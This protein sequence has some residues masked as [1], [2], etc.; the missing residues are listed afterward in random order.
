VTID[1]MMPFYGRVDQFKEAVESVLA[2]SDPDWRLVVIDD[3]Y[4]DESAGQWLLSLNDPRVVYLRNEINL[5]INLNFQA[6]IDLAVND[7][8]TIFGCDDVMLRDYVRT[9]T[10]LVE[11]HPLA[12]FVQ[13]GV[14]VIDGDGNPTSTLV[15]WTKARYRPRI[16]GAFELTGEKLAVSI[17]RGNWMYFP[18]LC[19]RR[20]ALTKFGFRPD[21]STVQDLALAIDLVFD[22]ATLV[23]DD[24]PV[25]RYRRHAESVSSW[26]A[27]E[28]SRF[29]EEGAFFDRIA[30][31]YAQRGW[32]KAH[33]AARAR[34]SSRM[35]AASR[36][37]AAAK[38]GNAA[39]VG[40][41]LRY[42]FLPS[43]TGVFNGDNSGKNR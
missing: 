7:W 31:E 3:C 24:V 22:G 41:L 39:A 33:R 8:V 23:V 6:C 29:A 30:A 5:G 17:T 10:S 20:D 18:S 4:P 42:A 21:L 15:D 37:P 13:P 1:I 32:K 16:R 43:R 28:G 14:E 12:T 11:S 26:R 35:N 36:L 38:S 2:Q 25:F 19:W 34:F 27:V 9:V 40:S